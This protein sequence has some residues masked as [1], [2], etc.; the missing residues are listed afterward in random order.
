MSET[1]VRTFSAAIMAAIALLATF[2]GG[3]IFAVF[4]ALI[5]TGIYYEWLTNSLGYNFA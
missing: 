5:A 2:A 1:L 4:V 3:Y